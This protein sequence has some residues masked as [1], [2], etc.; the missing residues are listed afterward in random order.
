MKFKF[1]GLIAEVANCHGGDEKYLRQLLAQLLKS[2]ADAVKFQPIIAAE[3]ISARHSQYQIF[4][5]LEFK[6][7]LWVELIR[8]VKA[9]GKKAAF[10]VYGEEPLALALKCR[11]DF[12]KIHAMDF[13]NLA[14]IAK[15]VKAKLPLMLSTGGATLPEIDRVMKLAKG[16]TVCLMVG[17]QSFPTPAEEANLNR[18]TFLKERYRCAVGYMDHVG[19]E[20]QFARTLPCLALLKGACTIEKHVFLKDL[21]TK[22]DWQSAFDPAE[23]DQ[24]KA[25]LEMTAAAL[26]KSNYSLSD[27]EQEYRKKYR[28]CAVAGRDLKA[29]EKL[30]VNDI[31]FL[32]IDFKATDR[33][34]HRNEAKLAG[35]ALKHGLKAGEIILKENLR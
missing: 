24:L 9:A 31:Q 12:V 14:L 1:P 25:D 23:L 30:A 21:K 26:G 32:R 35:R 11:V 6:T 8:K 2:R 20:T 16:R 13:D 28:R 10:D 19:R 34:F 15:I 5:E 17:F 3:F 22:Y 33:P 18:L 7:E 27:L 4:K 29:G